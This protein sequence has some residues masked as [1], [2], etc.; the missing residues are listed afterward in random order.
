MPIAIVVDLKSDD[1]LMI[2]FVDN[3][4][5]FIASN[6]VEYRSYL[7]VNNHGIFDQIAIASYPK[8]LP[9]L[10]LH[11]MYFTLFPCFSA[12]LQR[13]AQFIWKF[14]QIFIDFLHFIRII[15]PWNDMHNNGDALV[16]ILL[17]CHRSSQYYGIIIFLCVF[18]FFSFFGVFFLFVCYAPHL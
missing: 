15:N 9:P 13:I 2:R 16:E 8:H 10:R 4:I 14:T 12:T 11:Q 5:L 17:S 3:L 6:T 1:I 7:S 18:F